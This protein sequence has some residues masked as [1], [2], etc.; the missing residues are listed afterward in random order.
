[1]ESGIPQ[2]YFLGQKLLNGKT[3]VSISII[4]AKKPIVLKKLAAFYPKWQRSWDICILFR[5]DYFEEDR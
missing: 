4:M 1:M 3:G 5:G 2:E